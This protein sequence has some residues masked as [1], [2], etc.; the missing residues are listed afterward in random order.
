MLASNNL[1][2]DVQ[3]IRITLPDDA[4]WPGLS[5]S[6]LRIDGGNDGLVRLVTRTYSGLRI[7]HSSRDCPRSGLP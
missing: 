3:D 6:E 7:K 1:G 2:E 4:V 5:S